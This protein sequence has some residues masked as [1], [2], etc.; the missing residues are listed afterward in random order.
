MV[1]Q[2]S[3]LL[4]GNAELDSRKLNEEEIKNNVILP[5]L[6]AIGFNQDR[7]KFETNFT[8]RLGRNA[9][10]KI[11]PQMYRKSG[12]LDILCHE[13]GKNFFIIEVKAEGISIDDDDVDQGVS[14]ARA[15]PKIAPYVIITN[16]SET[17]IVDSINKQE[18]GHTL[19]EDSGSP[20]ELKF[21]ISIDEIL[22]AHYQELKNFISYTPHNLSVFNEAHLNTRMSSVRG[23]STKLSKKYVPELFVED[24]DILREF[25]DF[26]A[27]DS[28]VFALTGEGGVG[29]TNYM[30]D[31]TE[32]HSNEHI[33]LFYLGSEIY[34]D[35]WTAIKNDF[36]WIFSES[37]EIDHI[38]H[39]LTDLLSD[40]AKLI[41]FID[42][43]DE[44]VRVSF[45]QELDD[46][47]RRLKEFKNIKI[48]ISCKSTIWPRFINHLGNPT[49]LSLNLFSGDAD[50]QN[51]QNTP[52]LPGRV[53]KRFSDNRVTEMERRYRLHFKFEGLLKNSVQERCKLPFMMRIVAEVYQDSDLPENADDFMLLSAYLESKY[54]K[55]DKDVA[56]NTLV[57]IARAFLDQEN[58]GIDGIEE[59]STRKVLSLSPN[60]TILPELFEHYLLTKF[61][62]ADGASYISFYFSRIRDYLIAHEVANLA[63]IDGEDFRKQVEELVKT[64][65]GRSALSWYIRFA[66]SPQ[67]I[68]LNDLYEVRA[69]LFLQEYTKLLNDRFPSF[70]HRIIPYSSDEIGIVMEK[71]GL[72][73]FFGYSF[74]ANT[75]EEKVLIADVSERE[76]MD[77]AFRDVGGY[78]WHANDNNFMSLSPDE[79]AKYELMENIDKCILYGE[80]DFFQSPVLI[81]ELALD[82]IRLY[83]TELDLNIS[84]R[85]ESYPRLSSLYPI[86]IPDLKNRI[87][88]YYAMY[89][90]REQVGK[91][92]V[93]AGNVTRTGSTSYSFH[94]TKID[95]DEMDKIA[96]ELVESG[97][98]LQHPNVSGAMPRF[99]F[100]NRILDELQERKLELDE[101]LLPGPDIP[102]SEI[103]WKVL[104]GTPFGNN[105]YAILTYQYSI[106][107]LTMYVK[108]YYSTF[109]TAYQEIVD[110]HFAGLAKHL[111]FYNNLPCHLNIGLSS[112]PFDENVWDIRAA[113]VYNT[114]ETQVNVEVNDD[115]EYVKHQLSNGAKSGFSSSMQSLF[116]SS[117]QFG[118]LGDT[119]IGNSADLFLI[120]SKV[121]KQI[122]EEIGYIYGVM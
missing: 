111:P 51:N 27:S 22:S 82:M 44:V 36:N 97:E 19:F 50:L 14:Y 68:I 117:D 106:D 58:D 116:S 95:F 9:K 32:R 39:R 113:F 88:S 30:C 86:D 15:L 102:D 18:L 121:Y 17:R 54:Q 92:K 114:S 107:T 29:K 115:P 16:G 4:E 61:A 52:M 24:Q 110:Y 74:R 112:K 33:A 28:S 103:N 63:R 42:A 46:L 23:D 65:P 99:D 108:K 21:E 101:P 64:A 7:V 43:I 71:P 2:N 67:R 83:H 47:V 89:Y 85:H 120:Y 105:R 60:E 118:I 109:L 69:L 56:K 84:S 70:A 45:Q 31:L 78:W 48:C 12:R 40:S 104:Y 62:A 122:K 96:R 35:I 3:I 73:G 34:P 57:E 5:Y 6:T 11:P 79:A 90:A 41:I 93:A 75:G 72:Y 94:F 77:K 81:R 91:N 8:L 20:K 80:L 55:M 37:L 119:V 87:N 76:E 26:L 98:T 49:V 38:I 10:I 59:Q 13:N 100:L 53:I 66:S 25:S 1:D